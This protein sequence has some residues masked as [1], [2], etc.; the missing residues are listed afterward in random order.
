VFNV[1]GGIPPEFRNSSRIFLYPRSSPLL[2]SVGFPGHPYFPPDTRSLDETLQRDELTKQ[3]IYILR[4][5]RYR[6]R[7]YFFRLYRYRL[8]A[9]LLLSIVN[10]PVATPQH[11]KF[12]IR[13]DI[14]DHAER[15][16]RN[17]DQYRRLFPKL[18]LY[19]STCWRMII[20][21]FYHAVARSDAGFQSSGTFWRR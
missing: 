12:A 11:F 9:I 14:A 17:V 10:N 1:S 20:D 19:K 21:S 7:R 2:G 4:K 13:S 8:S 5:Y 15:G 6:Y 3:Q 16:L 18:S